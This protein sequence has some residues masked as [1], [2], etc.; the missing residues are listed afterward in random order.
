MMDGPTPIFN[1]TFDIEVSN[2]VLIVKVKD[3]GAAF[4]FGKCSPFNTLLAQT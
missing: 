4:C 2:P 3:V 1:Q